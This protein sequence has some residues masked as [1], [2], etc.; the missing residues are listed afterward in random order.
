MTTKPLLRGMM[1]L[2]AAVC[3]VG[4]GVA[5][6]QLSAA[7]VQWTYKAVSVIPSGTNDFS[8]ADFQQSVRDF[9]AIGG[10]TINFIIPYYQSNSFSSDIGRGH[11]TPSDSALIA[12]IQYVHSQGMKAQLS[13][14][15]ENWN[16]EWRANIDPSDR[17]AWYQ[18]YGDVLVHYGQIA[19]QQ[20][21]ELYQLGAELVRVSSQ[22][23]HS[24]NTQRWNGL[25]A[26]VRSVYGGSLTYSANRG[27]QGWASELPNI[28]FWDQLDY[29][30]VS[31]YYELYGDGSVP[32]LKAA[33]QNVYNYDIAPVLSWGKP[34]L[35]SEVGY[36]SVSGAHNQPWNSGMSGPYDAQ[37][38][39]N[40]YQAL[41]E[42]WDQYSFMQGAVL[43]WW[44]PNPH[45]GGSGNTDYTPQHKP[46]AE[47]IKN[48]WTGQS[49][50]QPPTSGASF[51]TT[52]SAPTSVGVGQSV[53]L[54]AS[55][56][57]SSA[58]NGILI[59]LEV[60][61][62]GTKV[63]QHVCSNMSFTAGETKQ[64]S[65]QWQP[66]SPGTYVFKIGVFSND[67][68]KY[69]HWNDAAATISIG[70]SSGGGT[71]PNGSATQV[72]WPT[73]EARVSGLQPFKA[74]VEGIDVSTYE[75]FWRVDDGGLVAMP[76]NMQDWPHKEALVDLTNWNWKG[77]GPYRITFVSKKNS[78]QQIISE[79]SIQLYTQ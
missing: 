24:D 54:T 72:W 59:D 47:T 39:V 66:Q 2:F 8:S 9:K 6:I 51:N 33:W 34:I 13:I 21:V 68:S 35:F 76:T 14:Y 17:N 79:K 57:S 67:W 25:I 31:A 7:T 56:N 43:W 65:T 45:Y 52:G 18:K 23:I 1:L 75:M 11:N 42:F 16:G 37:E 48:W 22:A 73:N 74:L 69:F 44:S 70:S 50:S 27:Q 40:D 26:R 4:V 77:A 15:L 63:F 62:G 28:Q 41:F 58:A 19:S 32:S 38:Q 29:V 20:G 71:P 3:L 60:Y 30:G 55:V 10:N 46:A 61:S 36:R 5:P 53:T 78:A 49:P 64:C 12:G